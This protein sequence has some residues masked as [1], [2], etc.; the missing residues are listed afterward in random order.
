VTSAEKATL[1]VPPELARALTVYGGLNPFGAPLWR[2]ALAENVLRQSFGIMRTMPDIGED[3]DQADMEPEKTEEGEFWTPRYECEG[4]ILERWFPASS[5]SACMEW[6]NAMAED[7][8][9]PM[10]GEY[11]R[12]GQYYMVSTE[13][14]REM[15]SLDFWKMLIQQQLRDQARSPHDPVAYLSEQLYIERVGKQL[16]EEAYLR[17]VDHLHKDVVKPMLATIGRTAQ[18]VRDDLQVELGSRSVL[19]AG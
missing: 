16:K 17:E 1:D 14:Y 12:H 9:T 19:A 10:M 6:E 2:V 3:A 8:F 5:W 11:P 18:V 7:G 4:W 13:A 15:P